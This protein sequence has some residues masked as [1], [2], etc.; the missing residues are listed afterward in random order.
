MYV[1][2][3][4]TVVS[5]C[6]SSAGDSDVYCIS[7]GSMESSVERV[8]SEVGAC[9]DNDDSFIGILFSDEEVDE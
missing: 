8:S 2:V 6:V 1:V 5:V 3:S 4:S 9:V 7:G